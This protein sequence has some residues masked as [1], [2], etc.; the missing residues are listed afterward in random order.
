MD[1]G[2]VAALG[3]ALMLTGVALRLRVRDERL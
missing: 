2:L 1:A 3:V